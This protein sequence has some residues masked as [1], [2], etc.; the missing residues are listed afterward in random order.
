[1]SKTKFYNINIDILNHGETLDKCRE[2]INSSSNHLL[3]FVNAHCFNIAQKNTSYK[4]AL[5]ACDLLLNDGVGINMGAKLAGIKLKENMNGTDFVPK[6]LEFASNFKQNVFFLGGKEG[7]ALAAKQNTELR[8]PYI[9]IVG[10]RNGYFSFDDDS[11]VITEII[12]KKT[13]I[14]IVGMGVPRQELWLTIN[15]EKLAGVKISV[16]GGAVLDF[17]SGNVSRAPLWMRKTGL[18]WLFRLIQ[19]P[20]RLF[21]RYIIGIPK[22]YYYLFNLK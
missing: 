19:E 17:I 9:S 22:Y 3:F 20:T 6:L 15:K 12:N 11:E 21:K 18:E 2:F 16:A 8:L 4:E 1:M 13:D 14:L 5:N 7:I 10:F